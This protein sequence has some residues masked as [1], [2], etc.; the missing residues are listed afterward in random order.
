MCFSI[1]YVHGSIAFGGGAPPNS[2][3]GGVGVVVLYIVQGMAE[4]MC[5]GYVIYV[6]C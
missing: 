6:L 3:V 2:R 5:F 1:S 4:G